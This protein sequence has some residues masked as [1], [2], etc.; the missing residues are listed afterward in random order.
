MLI[1]SHIPGVLFL[2]PSL[3]LELS[4]S[5]LI[6]NWLTRG[7]ARV[8]MR[9]RRGSILSARIRFHERHPWFSIA[10]IETKRGYFHSSSSPSASVVIMS[11]NELRVVD[12]L[13]L[14]SCMRVTTEKKTQPLPLPLLSDYL[15]RLQILSYPCSVCLC[16]A[17][18]P[19]VATADGSDSD[20]HC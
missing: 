3:P 9:W 11:P 13:S 14:Q 18:A 15:L 19:P 16:S 6:R 1:Q 20:C 12:S 7:G 4:H 2:L 5:G 10:P 17:S 8:S